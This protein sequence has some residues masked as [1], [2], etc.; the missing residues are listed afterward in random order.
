MLDS[1]MEQASDFLIRVQVK[2]FMQENTQ[3][4]KNF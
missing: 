3:Y 1:G 4:D 2:F